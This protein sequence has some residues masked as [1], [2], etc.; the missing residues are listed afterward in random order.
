MIKPLFCSS[1]YSVDSRGYVLSKRGKP[2]KPTI[3]HKGYE[4]IC[5]LV[6]GQRI[7]I[8]V[9]TAVARAFCDGYSEEKQVNHKDGNKRN[10]DYSNL[11]W[12]THKENIRHSI[13]VLGYDRLGGNNSNAKSIIGIDKNTGAIQYEFSSII[14][15]ARMFADGDEKKA[16]HI[17][18]SI[19]KVLKGTYD[20]KSYRGCI[21]KYSNV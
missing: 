20:K 18:T 16:R 15:A 21:W 12:I 8:S 9:H 19:W 4:I 3:N 14:D 17:Q 5:V 6:D 13:E 2:L 10:N 11:E 7:W 1:E